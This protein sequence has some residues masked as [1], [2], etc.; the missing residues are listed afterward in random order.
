MSS[1]A[2]RSDA[3][4]P[5]DETAQKRWTVAVVVLSWNGREDTLACIESLKASDWPQLR[6][7]VV[8]NGSTDGTEEVVRSRHP[9]VTLAQ[10]GS[11]LGF[12]TG[13]NVGIKRALD[14]H[15]DA[16]L[17]LNNDTFVASDAIGHLV[18]ALQSHPQ[19][20]AC[21]PVL[22]YADD[23]S[24]LWFAGAPFDPQHWRSG[25]ASDYERG[26][27]PLPRHPVPIDRAAGAALLARAD[28][29]HQVGDLADELFF[30][31]EDVDWSLRARAAGWEILLVPCARIIHKVSSS[32]GGTPHTPT[33]AY[34][35]TRNDLEMGRRYGSRHGARAF[36]RQSGCLV[37]HVA[38]ARHAAT[39]SRIKYLI[40][41]AEGWR[42]Y[43]RRAFG[44]RPGPKARRDGS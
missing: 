5:G 34:Y 17:V 43:R 41:T 24:R 33:T 14:D 27:T 37:L 11:N 23:P 18:A 21:S 2:T 6:V 19:A 15:V 16:V 44:A 9:E 20:A 29:L 13:N 1:P 32:Q 25:R 40:A 35:G 26:R 38:A 4:L 7:I 39:G 28:A 30:L 12:A 36:L 42:D 31:H 8:D 3:V 10:N 22:P